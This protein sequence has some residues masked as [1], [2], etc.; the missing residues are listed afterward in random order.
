MSRNAFIDLGF[1]L[2][3]IELLDGVL[4]LIVVD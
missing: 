3:P 2:W 4:F 1:P